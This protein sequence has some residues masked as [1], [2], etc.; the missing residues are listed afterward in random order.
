MRLKV[1]AID[2]NWGQ[3]AEPIRCDGLQEAQT[4]C[5]GSYTVGKDGVLSITLTVDRKEAEIA[6]VD[7]V[8]IQRN[9]NRIEYEK[10]QENNDKE[11]RN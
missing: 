8:V 11:N 10:E 9:I 7:K 3:W 1:K 2:Y 4:G 6:F 5:E